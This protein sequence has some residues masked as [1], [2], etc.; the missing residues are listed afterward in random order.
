MNTNRIA[1]SCNRHHDT[2]ARAISELGISGPEY[3]DA[4]V[5][6]IKANLAERVK[7]RKVRDVCSVKDC[8]RIQHAKELC[9]VH[10]KRGAVPIQIRKKAKNGQFRG[11]SEAGCPRQHFSR[12]FCS[13]HYQIWYMRTDR[14]EVKERKSRPEVKER[15]RAHDKAYRNKPEIKER[16]RAYFKVWRKAY[17]SKP[18]VKE[19]KRV[20]NKAYRKEHK[21]EKQRICLDCG[22]DI[23]GRGNAAKRCVECVRKYR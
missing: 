8:G 2:V 19:K 12:G 5:E 6:R 22:T 16:K 20:Y 10:Y 13:R 14:P 21:R 11:C 3:S 1:K 17:D 7:R 15:K 4:D 18:E 23:S 9:E